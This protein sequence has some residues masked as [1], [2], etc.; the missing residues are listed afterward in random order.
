MRIFKLAEHASEASDPNTFTGQARMTRMNGVSDDPAVNAYRV[1][2][3]AGAR[4]AWHI[5]SGP[6]LL[7]VL[8]G[9]CRLQREGASIAEIDA[10]DVVCIEPGER[11]WHG[12]G[13]DAPMTHLAV[14]IDSTT[15]WLD[16]VTPA[17]YDGSQD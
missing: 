15:T 2:F 1:E 17:E 14:N 10:G 4:T 5:H 8:T 7:I 11:H 6:Q 3:E 12:A 13:P 9:R 16:K